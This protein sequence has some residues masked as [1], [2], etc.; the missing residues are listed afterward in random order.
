MISLICGKK[1]AGKTK[2][3]LDEVARSAEVAKGDIV[4]ITDNK[5]ETANVDFKVR[6]L[7]ANDFGVNCPYCFR[8][9]VKGL[10]AGNSDIE[11][12]FID[13]LFRIIG[14][15]EKDFQAFIED[16]EWLE[17]EY[18]FKAALTVSMDKEALPEFAKKYAK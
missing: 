3:I 4:F 18:G 8:G 13:G 12:L 1:G 11:Y 5:F 16:L 7:Y 6:V 10:F 9:F 15:E 14:G 2:I 17:K